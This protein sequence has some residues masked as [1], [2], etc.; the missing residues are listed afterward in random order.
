MRSHRWIGLGLAGLVIATAMTM[1]SVSAP[2]A[3]EAATYPH[4][5]AVSCNYK[6]VRG[7]WVEQSGNS[8]WAQFEPTNGNWIDV[9]YYY[10]LNNGSYRL[11]VGCGGTAQNWEVTKYTN[12]YSG[13]SPKENFMCHPNTSSTCV[14]I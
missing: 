7:I 12:W 14:L 10:P 8:G 4:K 2:D 13:S 9:N 6:A 11:H 1:Q 3:A 5:G